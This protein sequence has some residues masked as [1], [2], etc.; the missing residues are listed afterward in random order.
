MGWDAI[1]A[2]IE[3]GASWAKSPTGQ[4]W[5]GHYVFHDQEMRDLAAEVREALEA[6]AQAHEADQNFDEAV[7]DLRAALELA[8]GPD[9]STEAARALQGSLRRVMDLQRRWRCIDPAD[10]K[11][12]SDNRC[13]RLIITLFYIMALDWKSAP[14]SKYVCRTCMELP[15]PII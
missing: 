13:G 5:G 9:S 3:A 11:A 6:R 8:G 4:I 14:K 12:W 7:G 15:S 10:Q 1:A 2:S